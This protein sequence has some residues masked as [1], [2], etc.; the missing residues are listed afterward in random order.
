MSQSLKISVKR[1]SQGNR[2][3][4]N[5]PVTLIIRWVPFAKSQGSKQGQ[6]PFYTYSPQEL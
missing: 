5:S 6:L 4:F 1:I 3:S 2:V